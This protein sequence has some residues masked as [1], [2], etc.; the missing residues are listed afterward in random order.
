MVNQPAITSARMTDLVLCGEQMDFLH[1]A[2]CFQQHL[3]EPQ[4]V[5]QL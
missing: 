4:E 3:T 5:V 2:G 1:L